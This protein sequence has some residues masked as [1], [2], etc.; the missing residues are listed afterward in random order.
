MEYRRK[1][2]LPDTQTL[3][4]V[5]RYESHLGRQFHR[6]MHELERLQAR[7]LGQ[8]VAAPLDVDVDVDV[9]VVGVPGLPEA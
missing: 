2:L 4:K 9:D 6:D 8:S 7:R 1:H 3:E 5:M